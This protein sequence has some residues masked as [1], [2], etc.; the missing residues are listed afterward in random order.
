MAF[1]VTNRSEAYNPELSEPPD[2][3]GRFL[4]STYSDHPDDHRIFLLPDA[5]KDLDDHIHW[6]NYL[7]ENMVEVG[8]Y[9]VGQ[10]FRNPRSGNYFAVVHRMI[11][12]HGA[13]GSPG[14]LEMGASESCDAMEE[15]SEVIRSNGGKWIR[16]GWYHIHPNQL[17]VFMSGTDMGTQT[18]SYNRP[19][20]FALV[21]N[22]QKC[23]CRA[24]RGKDAH[25]VDC[26]FVIDGARK[27]NLVFLKSRQ[28]LSRYL[29]HVKYLGKIR[30]E[31]PDIV[32]TEETVTTGTGGPVIAMEE[33]SDIGMTE[34]PDTVM[35]KQTEAGR[36]DS[37]DI[38]VLQMDAKRS[39]DITITDQD[40]I[41][42]CNQDYP[43]NE[44]IREVCNK[45]NLN[46]NLAAIHSLLLDAS[47]VFEGDSQRLHEAHLLVHN[48]VIYATEREKLKICFYPERANLKTPRL[49]I[50]LADGIGE[51]QMKRIGDQYGNMA[52]NELLII[53]GAWGSWKTWFYFKD[54]KDRCIWVVEKDLKQVR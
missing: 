41:R 22:P 12:I 14:Y 53:I 1:R 17:E 37:P 43:V 18:R 23:I 9:M 46:G 26:C 25:E 34:S 52:N 33:P 44:F 30:T 20:Q 29:R 13:K 48:E 35:E 54:S 4:I 11:P 27:D 47:L 28:S 3:R 32:R 5:L 40:Q 50:I 38:A 42:I 16:V 31:H 51:H 36:G 10:V 15:E 21:L 2:M 19:W 7:K 8:G 39:A 6:G 45:L 24:F 49:S